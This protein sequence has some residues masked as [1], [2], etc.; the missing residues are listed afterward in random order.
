MMFLVVSS[1]LL[2]SL[3]SV[4]QGNSKTLI[5]VSNGGEWGEW[6]QAEACPDGSSA[7]GFSLKLVETHG[8]SENTALTAIRLYCVMDID[9]QNAT[10]IQSTEGRLGTWISPIWC[11]HGN[12][13][14]F[15]FKVEH[16]LGRGD[17]SE[18]ATANIQFKC[19]DKRNFLYFLPLVGSDE[20]WSPTCQFGICGIRTKVGSPHG[21]G[22][23]PVLSDVQF[24]CC[25]N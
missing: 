5:S 12:L 22:D 9:D 18:V 2:L 25:A 11:L 17:H 1:L 20:E 24:T 13:V 8:F 3:F 21:H 14:A 15:S 10:L 23:D 7:R 4:G 19:S 6:G 16:Q